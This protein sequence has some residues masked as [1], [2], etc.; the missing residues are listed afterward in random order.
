MMAGTKLSGAWHSF[1]HVA[2]LGELHA[3]SERGFLQFF[4]ESHHADE[5]ADLVSNFGIRNLV[6]WV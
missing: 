5:G 1:T 2:Q 4:G 6:T 3:E